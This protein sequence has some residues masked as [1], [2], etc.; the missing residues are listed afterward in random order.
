MNL[1]IQ[2]KTP[3]EVVTKQEMMTP[4]GILLFTCHSCKRKWNEKMMVY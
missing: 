4:T 1:S 2:N 3:V